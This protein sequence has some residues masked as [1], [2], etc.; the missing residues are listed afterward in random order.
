VILVILAGCAAAPRLV[1]EDPATGFAVFR[2]GRLD[3]SRLA[4]L[5]RSGVEEIVVMDGDAARRECRLRAEICPGLRVRYNH[6]QDPR[7]P[8][9]VEF[10]EAYDQWI[11]ESR[12]AGRKIAFRCRHG[13]HRTGRLAAYY[14][15]RFQDRAVA[16][17][18]DEMLDEGRW[19]RR[20]PEL[21]PQ[22]R[23]LADRV[24]SRTCTQPAEHCPA[25]RDPMAEGLLA[26]GPAARFA[27]DL[28]GQ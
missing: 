25:E 22:V 11:E 17:A 8:L 5:C 7:R 12:L 9:S 28:C 24:A 26:A 13:W 19:M 23:A 1:D 14:R 4:K 15:L 21:Q 20:Y 27:D 3:R 16:D 6:A 10:L 18:L 2:T